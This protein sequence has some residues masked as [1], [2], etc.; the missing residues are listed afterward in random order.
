LLQRRFALPGKA[1]RSPH[2]TARARA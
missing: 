1:A 2:G